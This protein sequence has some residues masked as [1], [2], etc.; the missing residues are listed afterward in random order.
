MLGAVAGDNGHRRRTHV[1]GPDTENV[2]G[3]SHFGI[4]FVLSTLGGSTG[5][6]PIPGPFLKTEEFGDALLNP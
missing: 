6:I 2:L 4:T 5:I 1:S 3:R